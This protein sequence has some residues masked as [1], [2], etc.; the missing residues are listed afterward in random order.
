MGALVALL[1]VKPFLSENVV[2]YLLAFVGG[3]MVRMPD[4]ACFVL[5]T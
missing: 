3:I 1:I 5:V 2:H 4:H